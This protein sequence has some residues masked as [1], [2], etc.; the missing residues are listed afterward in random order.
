MLAWAHLCLE[1]RTQC[2]F[3]TFLQVM[4]D[5]LTHNELLMVVEAFPVLGSVAKFLLENDI[6]LASA[7]DSGAGGFLGQLP[8]PQD[9]SNAASPDIQR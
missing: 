4:P 6:L 3:P 9:A 7:T 1:G 8:Q 2:G 5:S